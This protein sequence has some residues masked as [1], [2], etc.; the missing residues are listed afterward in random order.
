MVKFQ[1]GKVIITS[2]LRAVLQWR[3]LAIPSHPYFCTCSLARRT[4]LGLES[5]SLG[6][7]A[8]NFGSADIPALL[9]AAGMGR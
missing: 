3:D 2:V 4:W 5:Y 1:D 7:L 8:A 6:A 9:A